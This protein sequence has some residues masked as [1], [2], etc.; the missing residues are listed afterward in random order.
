MPDP[1]PKP[2]PEPPP[3]I[4]KVVVSHHAVTIN[5]ERVEY[6]ALCGTLVLR[7]E[8]EKK[9]PP[10]ASEGHKA[11]AEIFFVAYLRDDVPDK[12][13]RPITFSF[14]G[15]PGSSSVWLHLGV[16]GP[17]RV[18]MG[19]AGALTAPPYGVI[20]NE[21]T[22]LDATDLVF[23]DPVGTGYSRAVQGEA[24]KD[25]HAF[26]RDI[27]SVGDFI[28]LFC[29]RHR[30]WRGPVYLIGESYGTLRAAGVSAYLQQRH[31]LYVNGLML[32]SSVLNF[33]TLGFGVGNDLPH[34]LFL[35]TYTAT[36]W[37]HK[38]LDASLQR[39][40]AKAVQEARDFAE[41]GYASALMRGSRL[42]PAERK[43]I[44]TR[45]ARLTG[46]S[47]E[48]CERSELRLEIFRFC[49]ELLRS[50]GEVVGRL[51]SRFTGYDKDLAGFDYEADPSMD[52][53]L[54]PYAAAI[55]DY[56][57][58]DLRYESDLPY[59]VL[60]FKTNGNWSFAEFTDRYVD[61]SDALR[62]AMCA[63][64]HMRV[65]V[66]NG[67]Y[68]LATP[69]FATEYTFGHLNLPRALEANISMR[70]Y[71]AG[72]MMYVHAPSLARMKRDLAAFLGS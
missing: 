36:A 4:D 48:F 40:L 15:G 13:K 42:G 17:R 9:D 23:I 57:R 46:M 55:N 6:T 24:N 19:D 63:N 31:G 33:Q 54:G 8:A 68:D 27:E 47:V 45:L 65:L 70:Y 41:G 3:A 28:R 43:R 2:V 72:H 5:G 7:E 25:F 14:N 18:D 67:Y 59:D 1:T 10:G 71:E 44:A 60:S 29:A 12:T 30:R 66:L 11:K 21:H 51:D 52:A 37:Y 32:V 39:N 26:T 53:I 20:D 38:R 61:T 69:F 34:I 49:K 35:P 58:G 62:R 56:L 22:L 50:R 16:L 64:P